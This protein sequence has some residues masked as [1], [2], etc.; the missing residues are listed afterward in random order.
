MEL[1]H[2]LLFMI[3]EN[4]SEQD[5]FLTE[6]CL[7]SLEKSKYNT[8]LVYN[9]GFWDNAK[10]GEYLKAFHLDC[11]IL[12][13]G[14]NVGIGL[15]RQKCFEFAWENM[16]N[17]EFISELHLDMAFTHDWDGPLVNYLQEHEEEPMIGCGIVSKTGEVLFLNN[18]EEPPPDS[19]DKMDEYLA[20]VKKNALDLLAGLKVDAVVNGYT[21]PCIH[22]LRV[23]KEVGGY[24]TRFLTGTQ[25]FEDDSLL[26]GYHYYYGTHAGWRPKINFNSMVCHDVCGQR[27]GVENTN[28]QINYDGLVRQYGAMG[29][30]MLSY[31]HQSP[32][33]VSFFKRKFDEM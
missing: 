18:Q 14:T 7:R 19:L 10:L 16:P 30:K 24:D 15:G 21:N 20:D 17:R 2:T 32:W 11:I 26:L 1:I 4:M 31:I 27:L 22:R 29:L 25:A 12:G 6:R 9:Q 3:R 5:L 13:D 28:M 23:L 33:H 8:V